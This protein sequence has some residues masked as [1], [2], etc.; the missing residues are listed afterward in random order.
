MPIKVVKVTGGDKYKALLAKIAAQKVGVK[1]GIL[2]GATTAEVRYKGKPDKD[3]HRNDLVW[4]PAGMS[5]A[6][7][8]AYNEFGTARTPKRPFLRQTVQKR[9]GEWLRQIEQYLT[10]RPDD[11]KGAM[12]FIG[13]V[14]KSDVI[15]EIESGDFTPLSAATAARKSLLKANDASKPLVATGQMEKAIDYEVVSL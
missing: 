7:Y 5:I 6:E 12:T 1:V 11:A 3:G 8:A 13:E 4:S 14:M 2:E 15:L 9:Q 10:G